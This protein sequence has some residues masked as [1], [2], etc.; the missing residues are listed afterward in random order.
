ME[1]PNDDHQKEYSEKTD[2]NPRLGVDQHDDGQKSAESPVEDSRAHVCQRLVH[3]LI[4]RTSLGEEGVSDVSRV[5]NTEANRDD[6]VGPGDSIY[7]HVPEVH[8]PNQINQS[9]YQAD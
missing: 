2:E 8:Q 3:S 4:A 1:Q 7:I 9:H 5:I 6:D